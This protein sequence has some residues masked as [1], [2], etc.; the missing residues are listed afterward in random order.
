LYLFSALLVS[1]NDAKSDGDEVKIDASLKAGS[2]TDSET[3]AKEEEAINADGLN[4]KQVKELREKV[5]NHLNVALVEVSFIF[6]SFSL[7][8]ILIGPRKF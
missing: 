5:R 6:S 8:G 3:L 7:W 2:G 1:G 4:A